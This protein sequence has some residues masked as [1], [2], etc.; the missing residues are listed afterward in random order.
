MSVGATLISLRP[1]AE[2]LLGT[3]RTEMTNDK[4]A[5]NGT[6]D[7]ARARRLG[8]GERTRHVVG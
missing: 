2:G 4:L 6:L 7:T 5:A 1:V 3:L 8:E